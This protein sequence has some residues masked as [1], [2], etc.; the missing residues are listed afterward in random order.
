MAAGAPPAAVRLHGFVRSRPG[1]YQGHSHDR[2][3]QGGLRAA[4][5]R[6]LEI[7]A[8]PPD[9]ATRADFLA[10]KADIVELKADLTN[11]HA[12]MIKWLVGTMIGC[13]AGL[14]AFATLFGYGLAHALNRA[15]ALG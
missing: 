14:Y 7:I 2:G 8:L 1:G 11:L 15:L 3:H 12:A 5:R 6:F 10:T 13:P 4:S 9:L